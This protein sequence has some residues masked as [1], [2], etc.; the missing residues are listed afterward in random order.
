MMTG[1]KTNSK[2]AANSRVSIV[3]CGDYGREAVDAAVLQS[4]ESTGGIGGVVRPGDSVLLKVNLLSPT[5]PEAA[6][7]THPAV[8]RAVAGAVLEAGGQPII[9]DAPGYLYAGGKSKALRKS[10]ILEAAE[11]LG[12]RAVQ[13]ENMER[14]FIRTE[15]PG[16]EW[17]HE[18]MAARLALESDVI[19]SL[20]KLKTHSGTWYT[21]AI[22]NMFGCVATRSRK[23]AHNL[24]VH[25]KFAG[26]V[27]DIFSAVKPA[28]AVMDAVVG[29]EGEGPQHGRPRHTG[30]IMA[31]R[32]CV[33]LDSVAS[34]L[35]GFN[36]LEILTVRN[37]AARGLGEGELDAIDIAG[38]RLDDVSVDY[39][40]PS[41]R[42]IDIHPW[43]MRV[44]SRFVKVE[45]SLVREECTRCEICM[46]SCP[47]DAITMEPYPVIDRKAC[48][49]CYCCSEMCPEGAMVVRKSRLARRLIR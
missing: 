34:T 5:G 36:P 33:A 47:A 39:E 26:A 29:M 45:P 11:Q 24:G 32:D 17:M 38:E 12:I 20:P 10:G 8:V 4:L 18:V 31:S 37:A 6:V 22:K 44:G 1:Q 14:P 28:L 15:V 16:A 42:Q 2:T 23:Q 49:E 48:I 13:F 40:K 27:V 3:R 7:T 46:K 9:A 43:L 21:G 25:E 30:L 19:I 35:I 41:G